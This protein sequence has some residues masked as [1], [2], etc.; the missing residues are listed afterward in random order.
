MKFGRERPAQTW[1][2][3]A[4]HEVLNALDAC[5]WDP[6][7]AAKLLGIGKTQIYRRIK[8]LQIAGPDWETRRPYERTGRAET[9]K[10]T[11]VPLLP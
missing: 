4:K 3:R 5:E 6:L 7:N 11:R 1:N 8:T 10:Q 2:V 9:R